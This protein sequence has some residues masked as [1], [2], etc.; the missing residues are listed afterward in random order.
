MKFWNKQKKIMY[1]EKKMFFKIAFVEN[2][3]RETSQNFNSFSL[4]RQLLLSFFQS[5]V[6]LSWN[7]VRFHEIPFQKVSESFTLLSW[8][9]KKVLVSKKKFLSCVI[10]K[11]KNL[12]LPTQFSGKVLDLVTNP[13]WALLM[14]NVLPHT[15]AKCT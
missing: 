3:F 4:F 13:L 5:L 2:E 1:S 10:I 15:I 9:T 6:W 8:K 7:F 11:T 14:L 12:C